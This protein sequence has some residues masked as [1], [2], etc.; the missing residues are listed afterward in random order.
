MI[1][2]EQNSYNE[3]WRDVGMRVM[4]LW[5]QSQNFNKMKNTSKHSLNF[6]PNLMYEFR[7]E[8]GLLPSI[9]EYFVPS[10]KSRIKQQCEKTAFDMFAL[11]MV[12]WDFHIGDD[13]ENCTLIN[14]F[15]AI[16]TVSQNLHKKLIF[17]LLRIF[18]IWVTPSK[19][20][21]NVQYFALIFIHF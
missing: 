18:R 1:E 5:G 20:E 12:I 10:G 16:F 6:V 7:G 3:V 4:G 9:L 19:A 2:Q 8:T 15:K 11:T 21:I 17:G 13:Q 14:D